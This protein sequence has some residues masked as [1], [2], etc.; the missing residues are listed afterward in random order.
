M[1]TAPAAAAAVTP[2]PDVVRRIVGLATCAPSVHNTQ[3]WRWRAQPGAGLLE[4][5]ADRCRQLQVADPDGRNLAVSCGAALHH[6]QQ[7][8][9]ALG[10]SSRVERLPEGP[11]SDL[12]A[13]IHLVAAQP[14]LDAG[15]IVDTLQRRH[16][17]RRRFT[18]WPMSAAE[19]TRLAS[20][21]EAWGTR[22]VLLVDGAQRA[23]AETLV[24]RALQLQEA[25]PSLAVEQ[26]AWIDRAAHDGV[27][28]SVLPLP[29][30]ADARSTNRFAP[31][32]AGAR[33][34]VVTSTDGLLVLCAGQDEPLAWLRGGESLS[35][36][37]LAATRAPLSVVPLSQVVEVPQTRRELGQLLPGS[38]QHPVILVRVGWQPMTLKPAA[39][40]SRRPIEEVL[41]I[42]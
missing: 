7:A 39:H 21:A 35:A 28:F 17:D 9:R 4:L 13:R 20:E 27:P 42:A 6:A 19:L 5:R 41:R 16:T 14:P 23:H 12:L 37:W 38:A 2:T 36:L 34:P 10:W 1:T 11:N 24:H 33:A 18:T 31:L 15:D 22:A 25:N 40:T 8:A 29:E 32:V 30:D 26:Q 3:P